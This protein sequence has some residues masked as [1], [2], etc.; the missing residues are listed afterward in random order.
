LVVDGSN[1]TTRVRVKETISGT[2]SSLEGRER[3]GKQV[4][5]ENK[6]S[7]PVQVSGFEAHHGTFFSALKPKVKSRIKLKIFYE[8]IKAEVVPRKI[9]EK[10][11]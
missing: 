2:G 10:N 1:D 11:V 5:P 9:W 3:E 8:E 4:K 7:N 6:V